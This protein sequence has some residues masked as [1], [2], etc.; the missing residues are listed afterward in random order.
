MQQAYAK[1]HLKGFLAPFCF[2]SKRYQIPFWNLQKGIR[3]RM[4]NP[5]NPRKSK[6]IACGSRIPSCSLQ[7]GLWLP[8]EQLQKVIKYPLEQIAGGICEL[9]ATPIMLAIY[10]LEDLIKKLKNTGKFLNYVYPRRFLYPWGPFEP[11]HFQADL[12][13]CNGTFKKRE[14]TQWSQQYEILQLPGPVNIELK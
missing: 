13:W 10:R 1:G 2:S 5:K 14:I 8:L 7:K 11:Y 6:S 12:I 9:H 4:Q 3:Y